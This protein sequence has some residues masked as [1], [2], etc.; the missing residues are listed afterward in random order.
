MLQLD[1][2]GRFEAPGAS[3]AA[4]APL[5]RQQEGRCHET[6]R[7]PGR[8]GARARRN[9]RLAAP[10]RPHAGRPHRPRRRHRP[11]RDRSGGRPAAAAGPTSRMR[12][13]IASA[14]ARTRRSSATRSGLTPGSATCTRRPWSA[15]GRGGRAAA[16]W[17]CPRRRRRRATRFVGV[18]PCELAAI[19]VQDRVFLG[20]PFVDPAYRSRRESAFVL[21]VDCGSPAG[22][23]FCASLGT[24][25]NGPRLRPRA[26]RAHGRR[27]PRAAWSRSGSERGA[28]VVAGIDHRRAEPRDLE[29]A[30]AVTA[31]AAARMGRTLDTTGL[32]ELLV[33]PLRGP[34]LGRG[35]RSAAS[36]AA[37]A[38]WSAPPASARRSRT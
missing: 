36:A 23:C 35:R 21:A 3:G 7:H 11:R 12:V 38:R 20:G 9:P 27:P 1:R 37:T 16:S 31:Q 13:A 4:F 26:H 17:P 18:R 29:A 33:P 22:T 10:A 24:G 6:R 14:S 25:P 34:A 19:R 28:E 2:F 15:G 32:K 5:L 8:R 30:A